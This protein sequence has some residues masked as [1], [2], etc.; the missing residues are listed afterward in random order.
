MTKEEMTKEEMKKAVDG[1]N[2]LCIAK[3][4]KAI[5]WLLVTG[6]TLRKAWDNW[7]DGNRADAIADMLQGVLDS[8]P[9]K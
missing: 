6:V 2:N 5:L 1:Y 8:D 4:C 9:D 3:Y 7:G